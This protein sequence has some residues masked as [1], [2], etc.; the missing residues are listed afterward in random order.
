MNS[1]LLFAVYV[2]VMSALFGGYVFIARRH[3]RSVR[4]AISRAAVYMPMLA[5]NT[6]TT[7]GSGSAFAC[8]HFSIGNVQSAPCGICGPL[9]AAA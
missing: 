2:A 8:S 5:H 3:Q 6:A 4:E 9:P 1:F 7:A